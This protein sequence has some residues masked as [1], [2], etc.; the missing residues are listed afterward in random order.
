LGVFWEEGMERR[1]GRSWRDGLVSNL[2][3]IPTAH[4]RYNLLIVQCSYGTLEVGVW[5]ENDSS[6][7]VV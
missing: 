1:R 4:W 7:I 2:S 3:S 5:W 6:M